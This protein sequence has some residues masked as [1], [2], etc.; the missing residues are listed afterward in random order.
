MEVLTKQATEL[1][2]GEK[3][4]LKDELAV[5][6]RE[7]AGFLEVRDAL[8]EKVTVTAAKLKEA[9]VPLTEEQRG[10]RRLAEQNDRDRPPGL[11]RI[12]RHASWERRLA[13]AEQE[14]QSVTASLAEATR[15]AEL[16]MELIR[17][18]G[19][20]ARG[21]A[22]RHHEL[23]LR[24]IATYLQ[25]LLRKHPD[26]AELNHLLVEYRVGPELPDWTKDPG[27]QEDQTSDDHGP[28]TGTGGL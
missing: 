24:R 12:R 9:Q 18:R 21:A 10:D 14:H 15:Q 19:A 20:V 5:L 28:T 25:Q 2:E 23:S 4:L 27:P 3:I 7:A 16:R 17:D 22:R 8:A 26:G 13:A 1:I 6:K 11:V